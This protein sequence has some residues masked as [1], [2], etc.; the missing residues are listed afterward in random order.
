[1]RGIDA[2]AAGIG[3]GPFRSNASLKIAVFI[4]FNNGHHEKSKGKYRGNDKVPAGITPL[5]NLP[6][7]TMARMSKIFT[8][9]YTYQLA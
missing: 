6:P 3:Q 4:A 5:S 9:I 1:M 8:P 2:I 7:E